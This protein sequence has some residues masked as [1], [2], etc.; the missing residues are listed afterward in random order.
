MG[1]FPSHARVVLAPA[2][3][4][5]TYPR[6]PKPMPFVALATGDWL[7]RDTRLVKVCPFYP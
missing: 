5:L 7:R 3:D 6:Q 2:R 1:R 4:A